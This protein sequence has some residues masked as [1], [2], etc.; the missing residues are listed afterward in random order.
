MD[1]VVLPWRGNKKI[2]SDCEFGSGQV[3]GSC[4][5][6]RFSLKLTPVQTSSP[7]V[8]QK[9]KILAMKTL[10]VSGSR[11]HLKCQEKAS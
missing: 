5:Q 6:A 7:V 3:T 1:L 9:N 8:A 11:K 2:V 4:L 10:P